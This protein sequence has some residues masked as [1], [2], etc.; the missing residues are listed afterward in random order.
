MSTTAKA[1]EGVM[2]LHRIPYKVYAQICR[3][4]F[5]RHVRM[6]YC[7]GTLELMSPILYEHE[8]WS[9]RFGMIIRA[10]TCELRITCIG[11]GSTTFRRGGESLRKGAGKEPD[12]S[13]YIA[14]ADRFIGRK[15]IDLDAGDPPPDLWIEV[16]SRGSSRGRLPVYAKLGVPEVWRFRSRRKTLTFLRLTEGGSYEPIDHS[17]SLPML[18]PALVLE[19]LAMSDGLDESEWDFRLRAWVRD[20]FDTKR[21]DC[22]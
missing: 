21:Q 5:N 11:T 7:D 12:Q 3:D 19:A 6:T 16:D 10:V 15:T 4:P 17:R 8:Q 13:F 14:H 9:Q 2:L 22:S 20:T 1:T 18:T